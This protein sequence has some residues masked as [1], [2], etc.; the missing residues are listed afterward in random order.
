MTAAASRVPA[1]EAAVRTKAGW[2]IRPLLNL[3]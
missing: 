3:L 2:E 1:R